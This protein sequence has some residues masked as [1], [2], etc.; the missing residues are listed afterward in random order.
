M[1]NPESYFKGM[2]STRAFEAIDRSRG[3]D[4][5]LGQSQG[6]LKKRSS[7]PSVGVRCFRGI[8]LAVHLA[9]FYEK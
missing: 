3:V 2:T 4:L 8:R 5:G 1:M 7:P 6:V 9:F